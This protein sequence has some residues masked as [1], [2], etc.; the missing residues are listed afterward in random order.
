[1]RLRVRK[2][3]RLVVGVALSGTTL[4]VVAWLLTDTSSAQWTSDVLLNLGSA[5]L[6]FAPIYVLTRRLDR[7]IEA[8]REEATTAVQAAKTETAESVSALLQR[9]TEF[10]HEVGR[11]LEEASTSVA[12][13]LATERDADAESFN[14]LPQS[15]TR[16][17]MDA[18]SNART[19]WASSPRGEGRG[20]A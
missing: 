14:A 11:R 4:L 8:V 19:T 18:A 7:H 2:W 9:V 17:A 10:E 13:R 20:C 12:G 6:L 3:N 1:M 5:V 16:F 15:P